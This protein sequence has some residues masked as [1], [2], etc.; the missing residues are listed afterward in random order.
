MK[1]SMNCIFEWNEVEFGFATIVL[2]TSYP[3]YFLTWLQKC[4]NIYVG[5]CK[6]YIFGC[7]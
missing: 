4:C 2:S 1:V 3:L 6:R 7:G 5:C